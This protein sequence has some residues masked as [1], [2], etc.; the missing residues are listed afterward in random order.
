MDTLVQMKEKIMALSD[1]S[2]VHTGYQ[3]I[4]RDRATGSFGKVDNDLL[5]RRVSTSILD[6]L[7]GVAGSVLFN[8]NGVVGT[9]QSTMSIRGRSTIFANPEP[10]IVVD[11]FPYNGNIL[12]INPDDVESVTILKDAAA[13]SI[14]GAFSGNGVIV[15]T[16][17]KGRLNQ[18]PRF[19]FNTSLTIG[20]K[21]DVYGLPYHAGQ[22]LYCCRGLFQ[23]GI[24]RIN[25]STQQDQPCLR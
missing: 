11:N 21:P 10:L 1:V 9:N 7:D 5:T 12:N 25:Y 2:V 24:F 23:S 16:T 4:P 15:I 6:R 17:K 8:N 14:W 3:V 18:A 22:G 20:R 13:A 19:E